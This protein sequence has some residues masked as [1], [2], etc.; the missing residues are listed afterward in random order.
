[1]IAYRKKELLN[2]INHKINIVI[3]ILILVIKITDLSHTNFKDKP[4]I[5][6]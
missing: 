4:E 3:L 5:A 2:F 6:G 1:M